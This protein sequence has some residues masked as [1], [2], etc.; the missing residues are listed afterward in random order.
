MQVWAG[1]GSPAY[2][3]PAAG[4]SGGVFPDAYDGVDADAQG[5]GGR[6]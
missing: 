3:L 1:Q 2:W 5:E 6:S 4:P